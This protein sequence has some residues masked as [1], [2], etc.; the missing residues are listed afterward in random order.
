VASKY[1][2]KLEMH[3]AN[4]CMLTLVA[5]PRDNLELSIDDRMLLVTPVVRPG[6][7]RLSPQGILSC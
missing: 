3:L 2:G 5:V 7:S 6:T 4:V 1:L